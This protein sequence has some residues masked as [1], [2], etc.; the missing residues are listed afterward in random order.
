MALVPA[1]LEA[2]EEKALSNGFSS[3]SSCIHPFC[4][5]LDRLERC[6]CHDVACQNMGYASAKG[7]FA[8]HHYDGNVHV[9]MVGQPMHI[10]TPTSSLGNSI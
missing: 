6:P 1:A 7:A 10:Q 4:Q 2:L 3:Q 8:N 5:L 9:A